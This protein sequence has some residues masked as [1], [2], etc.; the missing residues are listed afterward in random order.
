[1]DEIEIRVE[2]DYQP[3]EP[4]TRHYPGCL[5]DAEI[6]GITMVSTDA[7]IIIIDDGLL[8]LLKVQAIEHVHEKEI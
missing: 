6:C 5:E 3:E 1:M 2:F 4:M 7:E 8:D